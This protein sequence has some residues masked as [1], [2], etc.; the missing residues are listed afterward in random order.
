MGLLGALQLPP[1][2]NFHGVDGSQE[3]MSNQ[4]L[5]T[6]S[7]KIIF[8][9]YSWGG[10][11]AAVISGFKFI[12]SGNQEAFLSDLTAD[13]E[14]LINFIASPELQDVKAILQSA[15]VEAGV[16]YEMAL[17][18]SEKNPRGVFLDKPVCHDNR[19][20]LRLDFGEALFCKNITSASSTIDCVNESVITHCPKACNTCSCVDSLGLMFFEGSAKTCGELGSACL[21]SYKIRDYCPQTCS[22]CTPSPICEDDAAFT[23]KNGDMDCAWLSKHVNP[24]IDAKR[25]DKYCN[26][27]AIK[28]AC[29][30]TCDF[31]TCEDNA[32]F[33][34]IVDV[35]GGKSRSCRWISENPEKIKTRRS[36]YC[37]TDEDGVEDI[38]DV[39]KECRSACGL[40]E[41]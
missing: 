20:V 11:T 30:E 38:S 24:D 28:M 34:F 16:N 1:D 4:T 14:E 25:I 8:S 23:F 32:T 26:R 9:D 40:C 37:F 12:V 27:A 10:W 21:A 7:D 3:L 17:F 33:K 31:C 36:K 2:V 35:S 19:N 18:S 41:E 13:P 22:E 39:G 29:K 5:S 15:L 6:N